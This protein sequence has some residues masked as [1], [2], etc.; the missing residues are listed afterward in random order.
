MSR[1]LAILLVAAAAITAIVVF[2]S[3]RGEEQK[4][5]EYKVELD[6]AS[7]L[8]EG[9]D[10]R[11]AGVVVGAI[12]KLDLEVS[13]ARAI[14]TV[15]VNRPEFGGLRKDANCTIKPQSLIGEYFMDCEPGVSPTQ[16]GSGGT[17]PIA[18]T[19]GTIPP[20]LVLNVLRKPYREKLGVLVSELGAGFAARGGDVNETIRRAIPALRETDGVLKILA[21]ERQTL[22]QL[23]RDAD[24]VVGSLDGNKD[25]VARFVSEAK[26]TAEISARRRTEL[27]GTIRR[28]PSFERVLRPTL[29][30]L[31]VAARRQ[32]PALRN[33]R[34]AA[35]S[36]TTLLDRLGPFADASVPAVRA[37]GR[38]STTGTAAVKD[39]RPFVS[40][41]RA[42]ARTAKEPV[43]NLRFILEHLDDRGN[44]V[45]KNPLSPGGAGFTGLEAVLQYFYEQSQAI[46]VFDSRGY[47]LKLNLLVNECSN[48]TNGSSALADPERAKRCSSALGPGG[49]IEPTPTAAQA[50]QRS[51]SDVRDDAGDDTGDSAKPDATTPAPAPAPATPASPSTPQGAAPAP[52]QPGPLPEITLPGIGKV[53]V[54]GLTSPSEPR[55]PQATGNLLDYL[56]GG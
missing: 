40:R 47:V 5:L 55:D 43:T 8:T 6:N 24:T 33:L 12:E 7:G 9:A 42:V 44:A 34:V 25:D 51:V 15:S 53:D 22:R 32:T 28:L 39:A 13:T 18:N 26:D 50:Q 16:L 29:R 19:S 54:P 36:L 30:D 52:K 1:V 48:Y 21:D 27:A 14:A 56:L 11:V 4:G 41:L 31:G 17:V 3:G 46:N 20:D 10:L 38:A 2:A 35:P 37:L 45:E 23:T 49:K